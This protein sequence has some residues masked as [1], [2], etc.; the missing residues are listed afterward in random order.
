MRCSG[1]AS[2]SALLG[3]DMFEFGRNRATTLLWTEDCEL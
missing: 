1:E 3:E 2:D